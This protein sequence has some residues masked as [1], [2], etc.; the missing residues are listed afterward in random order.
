M[1]LLLSFTPNLNIS[2]A[3]FEWVRHP[4]GVLRKSLTDTDKL[5]IF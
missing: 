3:S 4:E 2:L 1:N 5:L